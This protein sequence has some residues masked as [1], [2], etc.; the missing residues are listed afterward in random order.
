MSAAAELFNLHR[1]STGGPLIFTRAKNS[2]TPYA[3]ARVLTISLI[4]RRKYQAEA[5]AS[6]SSRVFGAFLHKFSHGF[7]SFRCPSSPSLL[8]KASLFVF[9][10]EL[11][12]F[13]PCLY[14]F[15]WGT[16]SYISIFQGWISWV[17]ID[18]HPFHSLENP[19]LEQEGYGL[20]LLSV[21]ADVHARL[22]Q[23]RYD[24]CC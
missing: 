11:F 21:W 12:S 6:S 4:C 23:E 10:H 17:W 1:P 20:P 7:S 8:S 14:L 16:Y 22:L 3:P 9:P 15:C 24:F 13:F 2:K 5:M 18:M 19:L